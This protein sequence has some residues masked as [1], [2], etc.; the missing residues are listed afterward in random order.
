MAKTIKRER[1][2]RRKWNIRQKF[3]KTLQLIS[4]AVQKTST[5]EMKTKIGVTTESPKNGRMRGSD[6]IAERHKLAK[7]QIIN[8][9]S[10]CRKPV[11]EGNPEMEKS[12]KSEAFTGLLDRTAAQIM[13][14]PYS[15]LS[16]LLLH[17]FQYESLQKT[18]TQ[19]PSCWHPRH[20]VG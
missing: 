13:V 12:L 10:G 11:S 15:F 5:V 19:C 18:S 7:T 14:W 4:S 2:T 20:P 17:S 9:A 3:P 16:W 1:I 6:R 8:G